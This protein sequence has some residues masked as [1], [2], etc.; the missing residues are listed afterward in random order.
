MIKY[1]NKTY[2]YKTLITTIAMAIIN[3]AIL[4]IN[5]LFLITEQQ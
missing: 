5:Y 4:Y 1:K 2:T 3:R